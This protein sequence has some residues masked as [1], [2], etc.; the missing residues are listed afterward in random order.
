MSRIFERLDC[1]IG[2]GLAALGRPGYINLGHAD[3]LARRYDVAEMRDHAGAVLDAAW[4]G[5][6]RYFDAA[7][8]YGRAEEFLASW[9]AAHAIDPA[10]VTIGSKWGYA[11]TAGW[12]ATAEVHEVKEH[13]IARL[14]Q[15]IVESRALLQTTAE[16]I[17][18]AAQLLVTQP[19]NRRLE[20]G[21]G[22]DIAAVAADEPLV[23]AA[24]KAREKVQH[25]TVLKR[26][27]C[28]P[29]SAYANGRAFESGVLYAIDAGGAQL[30]LRC[31]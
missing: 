8:S 24:K 4:S 23:A 29:T 12:K 19:L 17:G 22:T 7:R 9:L 13:S 30:V 28:F 15:Q 26:K 25:L 3:D 31:D 10:A 20:L 21:S 14:G 27:L 6:V 2:L 18:L 5:G 1:R 16:F 11:Y